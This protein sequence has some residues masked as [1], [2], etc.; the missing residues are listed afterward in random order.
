MTLADRIAQQKQR[1]SPPPPPPVDDRP[2]WVK[3]ARESRLPAKVTSPET[4]S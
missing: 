4:L 3:R 2:E 1:V